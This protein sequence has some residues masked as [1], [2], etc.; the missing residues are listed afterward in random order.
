ME[1]TAADV[2]AAIMT[3]PNGSAGGPDGLRP[4]H[5]KDMITSGG[6]GTDASQ[7]QTITD[8]INAMLAGRTPEAVE[9][10]LFGG[11]LTALLKKDGGVRPIAVGYV[12]R[13]IAGKVACNRLT[14]RSAALLAPRQLG[15]GVARGCESAVHAARRYVQNMEH[16]HMVKCF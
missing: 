7:L 9:P 12:W 11:A 1:V 14:E 6:I 16:G 8:L 15:F 10:V 13:R 4:Q 2:K 3:F 5:L